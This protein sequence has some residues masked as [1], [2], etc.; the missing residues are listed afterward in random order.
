M[1][2]I[3]DN[4]DERAGRGEG[5]RKDGK[6]FKANNLR[7]DGS[8]EVGKG[9]PPSE[10]R[11]AKGDGRKRGK[12]PKGSKN[13]DKIW[14]RQLRKPR[15]IDGV[16]QESREWIVEGVVRR[17]IAKSDRAAETALAKA[18]QLERKEKNQLG[19]S[20]RE[21]INTWLAVRQGMQ[22]G[23]VS[24]DADNPLHGIDDHAGGGNSESP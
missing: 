16:T 11:F 7:D 15:T 5:L 20:D 8:Y 1:T 6:P 4:D 24:D 14:E 17:G 18:A 23:I 13:L 9:R 12:R 19:L 22:D 2:D 10:H 21:I 3:F